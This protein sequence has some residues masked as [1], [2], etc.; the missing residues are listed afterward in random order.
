[1]RDGCLVLSVECGGL[2]VWCLV[3]IAG[4]LLSE[5]SLVPSIGH[6]FL[7]VQHRLFLAFSSISAYI[8]TLLNP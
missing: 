1:M 8:C 7:V 2:A 5:V 3:L 6:W 4:G